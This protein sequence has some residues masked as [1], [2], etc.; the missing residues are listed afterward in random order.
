MHSTIYYIGR[1]IH[2]DSSHLTKKCLAMFDKYLSRSASRQSFCITKWHRCNSLFVTRSIFVMITYTL[3]RPNSLETDYP[4]S[5]GQYRQ[6]IISVFVQRII[7]TQRIISI[8]SQSWSISIEKI[9]IDFK[10]RSTIADMPSYRRKS[11]IQYFIIHTF[12][13]LNLVI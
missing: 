2:T 5:N 10:H 7:S 4:R 3:T 8:Q 1:K 6:Q 12:K 9:F 13:T 11:C